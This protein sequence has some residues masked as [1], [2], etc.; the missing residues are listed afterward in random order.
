[1]QRHAEFTVGEVHRERTA[2]RQ[3]LDGIPM[4]RQEEG[5]CLGLLVDTELLLLDQRIVQPGLADIRRPDQR[6]QNEAEQDACD[7]D[8]GVAVAQTR[9]IHPRLRG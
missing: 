1:M 8:R 7:D 6:R 3:L 9:G 4:L 2:V 5:D